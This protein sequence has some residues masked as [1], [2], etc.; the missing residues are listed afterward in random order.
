MC[1]DGPDIYYFK[2]QEEKLYILP[3]HTYDMTAFNLYEDTLYMFGYISR[4]HKG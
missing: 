1:Q 2:E 4:C 3:T